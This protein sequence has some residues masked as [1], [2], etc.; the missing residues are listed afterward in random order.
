MSYFGVSTLLS[1]P[2]AA[3]GMLVLRGYLL[4]AVLLLIVKVVQLALGQPG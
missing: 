1:V 3:L 2:V 4:L